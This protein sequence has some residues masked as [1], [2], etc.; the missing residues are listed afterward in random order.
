MTDEDRDT[1]EAFFQKWLK[2]T[3]TPLAKP[4]YLE[5]KRM[6]EYHACPGV[7]G[8]TFLHDTPAHMKHEA[9]TPPEVNYHFTLGDAV[10]IATLE[11]ERFDKESGEEE[12]FQY[13]PDGKGVD[14]KKAK[15]AF[16]ADPSKPIVTPELISKARY[17]RDAI[18]RNSLAK[19]ILSPPADKELSG[20]AWDPDVQCIRKIRID[21]RPKKGNYLVDLKTCDS[22]NEAKFWA[23]VKKFKYGAKAAYYLDGDA[24]ITGGKPRPYFYLIAVEGPKAKTQGVHDAPYVARVFEIAS[25]V[26]DLSLVA[27]GRAFYLDRLG[28]FAHAA[29]HNDWEGHDHQQ[30]AEVL[31]TMRPRMRFVP[32]N[33]RDDEELNTGEG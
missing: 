3:L 8:S 1:R 19:Q 21:F 26:D 24:M 10:H 28:K 9:M 29:R 20:F 33:E 27:E 13:S 14:T 15:E 32:A 12:F 16:A 2:A 23:S 11:P 25:P 31:Y 4:H 18:Y 30:E 6:A 7:N 22:T 5:K 17:M